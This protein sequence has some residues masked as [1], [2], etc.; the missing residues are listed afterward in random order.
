MRKNLLVISSYP[1]K[2]IVHD[3]KVVGVATYTKN[4]LLGLK[5][6]S[7]DFDITVLAEKLEGEKNYTENGISIKR[8][9]KRK[10]IF[11]Y[12]SLLQQ[13]YRLKDIKSIV[14][15]FELSMFGGMLSLLFLPLFLLILNL[16]G[17]KVTVVLHQ[18][19][20][21]MSEVSGHIN[22]HEKSFR[23][24]LYTSLI[25][26]FY[27]SILQ[28]ASKIIVFEQALKDRLTAILKKSEE[29][30]SII[31]HGVEDF[32]TKISKEEARRILGLE[33]DKSIVL[34]FGYIAW[35][36]GAD[37]LVDEYEVSKD[38]K[39]IMAGGANPNHLDKKYYT[40]YLNSVEK[41]AKQKDIIVTGF[42]P[43][44]KIPLYFM[45]SDA[46]LFPYRALISASGPLSMAFSFRKPILISDNL[47]DL[48]QTSDFK[49]ALGKNGLEGKDIVFKTSKGIVSW[50]GKDKMEKLEKLS[51]TM[52]YE[53]SWD[54]IGK[55]YKKEL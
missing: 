45:A 53:R 33:Q 8:V 20:T 2:G 41:I 38:I 37:K 42:V 39:L 32:R 11:A 3:K 15:E 55:L 13:I 17:K 43:E 25:R 29:K 1:P 34:Y 21:D 6:V 4:T 47:K 27:I 48:I 12:P 35:Y 44:E 24:N 22:I 31:P 46:V 10:S 28:T 16:L 18:V 30:I 50:L 51:K 23:T 40:E 54:K 36:K 19:I 49:K 5:K 7:P 26:L 14:L 52:S 9:W